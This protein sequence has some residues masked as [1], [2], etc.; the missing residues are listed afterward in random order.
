MELPLG[1]E[2]SFS[3][4]ELKANRILGMVVWLWI[5]HLTPV[6]LSSAYNNVYLLFCLPSRETGKLVL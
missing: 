5:S 3:F 2:R 4:Y 6:T 1:G